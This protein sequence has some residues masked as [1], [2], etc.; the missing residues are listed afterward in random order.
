VASDL[1]T[2]EAEI[3]RGKLVASTVDQLGEF[4]RDVAIEASA[5]ARAAVD[6][7]AEISQ[8]IMELL[9]DDSL[10]LDFANLFSDDPV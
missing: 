9:E 4:A 1:L 7:A 2:V 3:V 10:R 8:A 5:V 6:I